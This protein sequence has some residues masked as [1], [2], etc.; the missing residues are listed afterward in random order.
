VVTLLKEEQKHLKDYLDK[1]K[2]FTIGE[3]GIM[4]GD[5]GYPAR[6][7]IQHLIIRFGNS[8]DVRRFQSVGDLYPPELR[9]ALEEKHDKANPVSENAS[10]SQ[11]SNTAAQV[12][13]LDG[14]ESQT[15][16]PKEEVTARNER[17]GHN[18]TNTNGLGLLPNADMASIIEAI[19]RTLRNGQNMHDLNPDLS[20]GDR[21]TDAPSNSNQNPNQRATR[22]VQA[23]GDVVP[24]QQCSS[25]ENGQ[26][27]NAK[28]GSPQEKI[29]GNSP[30][31]KATS[32]SGSSTAMIQAKQ[33]LN[34]QIDK[35]QHLEKI[36]NKPS[37]PSAEHD[38]RPST[39]T[40]GHK[41]DEQKAGVKGQE[42]A[43]DG[44][45]SDA[46]EKPGPDKGGHEG[47]DQSGVEQGSSTD[48][49]R[50]EGEDE[51]ACQ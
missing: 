27:T 3:W 51:S 16:A 24:S 38:T 29:A 6:Q 33:E 39:P 18:D 7:H 47:G 42:V 13:D 30:Q 25:T 10:C 41:P 9:H 11:K 26:T 19:N 48:E 8:D 31:Q 35:P 40:D 15:D 34:R 20:V 45:V 49:D 1:M 32:T 2:P 43:A 14:E 28:Q 46:Q 50:K 21:I 23:N 22:P 37:Q 17:R 12:V 5:P 36:E 44:K 4:K